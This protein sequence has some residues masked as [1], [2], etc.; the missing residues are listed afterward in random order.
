MLRGCWA[1]RQQGRGWP[2][3]LHHLRGGQ[4]LRRCCAHQPTGVLWEATPWH[5]LHGDSQGN[6][7]DTLTIRHVLMGGGYAGRLPRCAGTHA[8][9]YVDLHADRDEHWHDHGD[10]HVHALPHSDG[11]EHRNHHG[12]THAEIGTTHT[13]NWAR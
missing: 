13:S 7:V 8:D 9:G 10:L 6:Y 11:D 1:N 4:R 2:W 3:D 12:H 5:G